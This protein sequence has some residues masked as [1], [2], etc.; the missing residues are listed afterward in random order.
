MKAVNSCA[1]LEE[2]RKGILAKKGP[3]SR[4]ISVCMGSSCLSRGSQEIFTALKEELAKDSVE[5][6]EVKATGCHGFCVGGPFVVI[7]PQEIC[8]VGLD[9]GDVPEIVSKTIIEG[10]IVDELVYKDTAGTKYRYLS[11]IPFYKEQTRSLVADNPRIDPKSIEDYIYFG[12]YSALCKA[13]QEMGPDKI[14][15]EVKGA[16]LRGRGG[17]GFPAGIKWETTKNAV[18]DEKFVIVNAHEGEPGAFMDRAL[19]TGNPHLILEGLTIGAYTIGANLGFIYTRHDC[20]ELLENLETAINQAREMGLLGKNI[21]GSGFDFDVELQFDVGIFVSGE[22]SAL[23]RSIEGKTPEPRSKYVR[24]AVSGILEKP[25]NL[26]NVE[27]WANVP[28]IINNGADWYA[29]TDTQPGKE[30]KLISMSGNVKNAGV[31]E[32]PMGTSLREIVYN[33]GGGPKSGSNIKAVHFGGPMGG[34]IPENLLDTPL[35]FDEL[36]KLGA[37]LGAGGLLV[38]GEDQCMV[39]LARYFLRFLA[40]ESCGKCVPCRE[41]IRQT[42]DILDGICNG[43]GCLEDLD[44]LEEIS[45]VMEKSALCGLGRTA[46]T[47]IRSSLHYFKEDY[48]AHIK[49]G[50]CLAKAKAS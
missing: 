4:Y 25:S 34:S 1:E 49:E 35:D 15:D 47:F 28:F 16:N 50:H 39:D 8:Y 32:V 30:T 44:L 31:V 21:L 27:T 6:V 48:E 29:G 46:P 10:E 24:T 3:D 26:N 11:E 5:G 43:K 37:P 36:S 14:V 13:M 45:E 41:G 42:L 9:V 2:L 19:F 12:G 17:A 7:Y 20:P 22:S 33:I 40:G 18:S 23:M 38:I